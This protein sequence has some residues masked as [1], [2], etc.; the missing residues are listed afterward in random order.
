M[1]MAPAA[2]R[3]GRYST[4]VASHSQRSTGMLWER[5]CV[6]RHLVLHQKETHM[7]VCSTADVTHCGWSAGPSAQSWAHAAM[8]IGS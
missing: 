7:V 4:L 1:I 5:H 8:A 6:T 2:R 3:M